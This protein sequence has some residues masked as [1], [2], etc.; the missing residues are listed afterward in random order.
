MCKQQGYETYVIFKGSEANFPFWRNQFQKQIFNL[1]KNP[2]KF[3]VIILIKLHV[4]LTEKIIIFKKIFIFFTSIILVF[5]K[6][7][8]DPGS[9]FLFVFFRSRSGK[10][11]WIL[12]DPHAHQPVLPR[13][14]LTV[15]RSP[16]AQASSRL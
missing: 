3:V 10:I 7:R 13:I 9:L 8:S 12:S 6:S 5:T 4:F 1:P 14:V 2:A 15:D 11:I 16:A